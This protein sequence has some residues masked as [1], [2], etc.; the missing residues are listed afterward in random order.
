MSFKDLSDKIIRQSIKS[1][2]FIDDEVVNPYDSDGT[3]FDFS[4]TLFND[5]RSSKCTLDILK[6]DNISSFE[7]YKDFYLKRR[8]LL[9]LDWDLKNGQDPAFEDALKIIEMAA[10]TPSLHFISIY[11]NIPSANFL[12]KIYYKT[13]AF[14]RSI[15]IDKVDNCIK[16]I[17][18]IINEDEFNANIK[19]MLREIVITPSRKD[20]IE[21]ELFDEFDKNENSYSADIKRAVG[22][23]LEQKPIDGMENIGF[24]INDC[25]IRNV[26]DDFDVK[27]FDSNTFYINDTIIKIFNKEEIKPAVLFEKLSEA[28]LKSRGNF[29]TLLGL[30]LRNMLLNSSAFIEKELD[31]IKDITFFYHQWKLRPK[32]AFF[33]FLREI[34]KEQASSF[35]IF[36]N[37][38]VFDELENYK[39]EKGYDEET[40]KKI[41][42]S[43]SSSDEIDLGRLNYYYNIMLTKRSDEDHFNFGD[44]FRIFTKNN[45]N[46]DPT[47]EYLLNITSKC[48]CTFPKNIKNQFLFV[49]GNEIPISEGLIKGDTDFISY[50]KCRGNIIAIKWDKNPFTI[51]IPA[52]MN[53]LSE[54]IEIKL[55]ERELRISYKCCIKENY[56]QRI[57]NNPFLN[58]SRVGISFSDLK[59]N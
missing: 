32:E 29:L 44:I 39:T 13:V 28:L 47:N 53:N 9:I 26:S 23:T 52:P 43:P 20:E 35:L 15:D 51:Y 4:K 55:A 45:Q 6:F 56:A 48:D 11:T 17:L 36:N 12:E 8:D 3:N 21:K 1:A 57:A 27:L 34:W 24:K 5:F 19:R 22:K 33:D 10:L 38:E 54:T 41:K 30:E 31:E 7:D 37:P 2:V 59:K 50:I 25:L 42:D 58:A 16:N 14:L 49:K 40:F 46:Y 18:E